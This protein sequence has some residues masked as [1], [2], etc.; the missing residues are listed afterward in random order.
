MSLFGWLA[1]YVFKN[2]KQM[3]ID[4]RTHALDWYNQVTEPLKPILVAVRFDMPEMP[5]EHYAQ[6]AMKVFEMQNTSNAGEQFEN[7]V[8]T[9]SERGIPIFTSRKRLKELASSFYNS[10][11]FVK[12]L[13]M[14]LYYWSSK[15]LA[16]RKQIKQEL[17]AN[18]ENFASAKESLVAEINRQLKNLG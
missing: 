18:W 11:L 9:M 17:A 3:F 14:D 4:L 12:G 16:E 8:E 5:P 7:V 6:I 10:G 15:D 1:D 13:A 2:E